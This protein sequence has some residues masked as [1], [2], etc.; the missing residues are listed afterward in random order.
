V[1][2]DRLGADGHT[3]PGRLS[4]PPVSRP[5]GRALFNRATQLTPAIA[6]LQPN[7]EV[8][9]TTAL[10]LGYRI[11]PRVEVELR[12]QD[13]PITSGYDYARTTASGDYLGIG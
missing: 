9:P 8:A 1:H 10:A 7:Q 4:P 11:T 2:Y 5:G 6:P 13:I 3:W 12:S